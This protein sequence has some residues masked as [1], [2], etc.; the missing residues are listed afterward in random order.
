MPLR[1]I[2][3]NPRAS[4]I[5]CG[6]M[7]TDHAQ[8]PTPVTLLTMGRP[9]GHEDNSDAPAPTCSSH[10]ALVESND[11]I[12]SALSRCAVCG[13]SSRLVVVSRVSAR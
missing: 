2:K 8:D 12:A 1:W 5:E 9:C 6:W 13:L 4:V 7:G 3:R 10:L 11:G